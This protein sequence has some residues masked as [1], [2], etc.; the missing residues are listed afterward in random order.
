MLSYRSIIAV[1]ALASF[2]VACE[3]TVT[4]IPSPTPTLSINAQSNVTFDP[5]P[6][7]T[8]DV[9]AGS[10][11]WIEVAY[12]S[13]AAADLMYFEITNAAGIRLEF[14]NEAGTV[15]RLVSRSANLFADRLQTLGALTASA[16]ATDVDAASVGI[17]YQCLG[18]CVAA[19]YVAS[20]RFVRLVNE[21]SSNRTNVRLFAYATVFDDRNEPNDTAGS[22]S[23]FT[24]QAL[25]DGPTGALEH[26]NDRDF[27]RIFCGSSFPE[28][29]LR[30]TLAA[31]GFAGDVVMIAG[32]RTYRPGEP[33]QFLPCGSV[34]EVR[35]T[36]G[37]AAPPGTSTYSIV[38][39]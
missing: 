18:P 35:T 37:T 30:L 25:G 17:G 7:A 28:T 8:I 21:T 34:V 10:S 22:A 32:G 26:V 39:D 12:P 4:P 38:A 29:N 13:N 19:P 9:P 33:T 20:T 16:A 2:L 15:R 24:V 5:S 27:H 3:V 14:Y 6:R 23:P 11:R 1:I 36:D 31:A